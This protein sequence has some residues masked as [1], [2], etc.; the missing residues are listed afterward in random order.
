MIKEG[1]QSGA[2]NSVLSVT[3]YIQVKSFAD[4]V[5]RVYLPILERIQVPQASSII[6][7][8]ASIPI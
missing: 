5:S 2:R 6:G 3:T 8:I 1:E 4:S 7:R